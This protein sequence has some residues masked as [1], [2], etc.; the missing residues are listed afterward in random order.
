MTLYLHPS[1][2]PDT[3]EEAAR[4]G[5]VGVKAYP[6]GVTTNSQAGVLD[7]EQYYPVFG[8]MQTRGLV[9]NLHGEVPGSSSTDTEEVSVMTAE[10]LFLP[11]LIK[12][13]REFPH[14]KIVLEH[15][16]TRQALETV[17][18]CGPTVAATITAHHLW[19][20]VDDVC[21]DVFNFCKPVAKTTVDRIALLQAAVSGNRK[22]FFGKPNTKVLEPQRKSSHIDLRTGSDSAPHTLD[23]KKS[24]K[25]APAGCFTQGWTT[26]LV[27]AAIEEGV[28]KGWI[29]ESD[30][31]FKNL[32]GF[33]GDYGRAFYNI[34][35][36]ES[37]ARPGRIILERK[38]EKIPEV[39]AS[40]DQSIQV[41]PFKSD[42]EV[43]T[44]RWATED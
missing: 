12:L 7:W 32:Q 42:D 2:T 16:T 36:P 25:K 20:T 13:H 44:L 31:L 38:G 40:D 11:T 39:V 5:I 41:V 8:A 43:L 6:A 15:C 30:A 37:N 1:V 19:I 18:N 24:G 33:L 14:L 3:I 28:R 17:M 22:F 35:R 21:G 27:V 34:Q 23:A 9:L 26:Q 4:A 10:T 29:E